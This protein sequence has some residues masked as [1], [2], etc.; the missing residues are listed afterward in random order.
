MPVPLPAGR[1][2][3]GFGA[4]IAAGLVG[5]LL[6]AG[7]AFGAAQFGYFSPPPADTS[8]L[9]TRLAALDRRIGEVAA[10]P[11]PV[12]PPVAGATGAP[13][14]IAPLTQR[15]ETLDTARAALEAR[16]AAL[17]SRPQPEPAAAPPPAAA[18]APV[19][20]DPVNRE[21]EALKAALGRVEEA[22]RSVAAAPAPSPA[23]TGPDMAAV[24]AAIDERLREAVATE[25]RRAEAIE[26]RVTQLSTEIARQAEALEGRVTAL[27]GD[28]GKQAA[29]TEAATQRLATLDQARALGERSA[30]LVG[31]EVLR[32]SVD[33]G[34]AY[35][36]ELRGALALGV[37]AD[38]LAPLSAS[39]ERGVPT[40][41]AVHR[42]FAGL[43]PQLVRAAP[44]G[45]EGGFFDRLA[46]NAQ[47]L[48]RVRP[49]GEAAGDSVPAV[50]ARIEAKLGRGDLAGALA[51][52]DALP[53]PVKAPA[54][55]WLVG[56]R[57][58]FVADRA[59]AKVSAEA[60]AALPAR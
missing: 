50:V 56:A 48:V 58:R 7:L 16:I 33:R 25:A 8:A 31:I 18:P 34:G 39:A 6:T 54:Q 21:I 22:Q 41:A 59:L 46:S 20:L 4:L 30:R 29:A 9:E 51:D 32:A 37:D 47:G 26:G 44:T 27:T 12:A 45:G 11:A 55:D 5:A 17:E 1:S 36:A 53:E 28:L 23:P 3:P 10:R 43:A 35:A 52:F 40:R 24:T 14:D 15:L 19:D 38:A 57:A 2:G 42:G 60:L 13:L 49:V